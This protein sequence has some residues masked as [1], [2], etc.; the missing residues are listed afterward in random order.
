VPPPR[1]DVADYAWNPFGP[2][3][4]SGDVSSNNYPRYY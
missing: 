4:S 1:T 3:G 2:P